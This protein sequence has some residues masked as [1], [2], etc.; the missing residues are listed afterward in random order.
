MKKPAT[1]PTKNIQ[2]HKFAKAVA[3]RMRARKQAL[4]KKVARAWMS[5]SRFPPNFG[6]P[7]KPW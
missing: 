5:V 4:E 1:T 6:P 3:A 7:P 2:K